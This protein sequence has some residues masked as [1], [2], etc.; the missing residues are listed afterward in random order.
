MSDGKTIEE[1][2][3]ALELALGDQTAGIVVAIEG[4]TRQAAREIVDTLKGQVSE[5]DGAM[6]GAVERIEERTTA[7]ETRVGELGL[8][9]GATEE[10]VDALEVK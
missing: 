4:A 2:V 3:R 10:R 5:L 9:L 1:R 7:L 8:R 6:R